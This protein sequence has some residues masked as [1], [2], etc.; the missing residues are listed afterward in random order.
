ML[1]VLIVEDDENYRFEIQQELEEGLKNRACFF[2]AETLAE[3]KNIIQRESIQLVLLDIIFPLESGAKAEENIDYMAGV[4]F[5][6]F[7]QQ[8][9]FRANIVILSSQDKTFAVDL[10]IRYKNVTDYIFKDS[11]WKEIVY[12]IEKQLSFIRDRVNLLRQIQQEHPF[13]GDSTKIRELK[14]FAVKIGSLDTTILITGESGTGKEVAARHF[15]GLSIRSGS[16]FVVVNCAAVPEGLFESIL[17]GHKKGAFTGAQYDQQG[18]FEAADHGTIFLDEIG[19]LPLNMQAK[20]LRVLQEKKIIPVG[21]VDS[22]SV[23]VR[24]IAATNRS[25]E[26]AVVKKEFREDLFYRLNVLPVNMP[27]LRDHKEDIPQIVDYFLENFYQRTGFRKELSEE[28]LDVLVNY[29]W[30]GNVRE[31][32]NTVERIAILSEG[33]MISLEEVLGILPYSPKQEYRVQIPLAED[34]YKVAKNAVLNEFHRKFFSYHLARNEYQLSKT[35]KAV[36][37]NR[38]DLSLV[39]KKLGLPLKE[40][41]DS[42]EVT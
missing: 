5:L 32:K 16:P 40:E 38:N 42:G 33:A 8:S 15:H 28:A 24:V 41:D 31:L 34:D 39:V 35:A 13:I 9:G 20:L 4:K 6:E 37:Y 19:E 18:L 3:A 26:E 23:D 12:K 25:L 29:G 36:G 17:F 30:P 7:A 21:K 11:S 1:G 2:Y 22:L 27:S 10:L 14:N